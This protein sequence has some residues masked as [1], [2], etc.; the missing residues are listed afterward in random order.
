MPFKW[1]GACKTSFQ[2]LK[3]R[4]AITSILTL[5][6]RRDGFVVFTDALG[7]GLG[8]VLMHAEKVIA[9][10]LHQLKEQEKKYAT[11]I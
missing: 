3:K 2:E 9:Y 7:I 4:L 8:C 6:S 10:G 5:P 1:S 11:P